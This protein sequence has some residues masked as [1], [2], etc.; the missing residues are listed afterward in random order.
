MYTS[1]K[2]PAVSD[3]SLLENGLLFLSSGESIAV[4]MVPQARQLESGCLI[5]GGCVLGEDPRRRLSPKV[6]P[7]QRCNLKD[8]LSHPSVNRP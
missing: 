4:P 3:F 5:D 2:R 1:T 8:C 7:L 6:M